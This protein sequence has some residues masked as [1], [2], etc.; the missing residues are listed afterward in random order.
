[1]TITIAPPIG[2][3][4]Q[5]R[6]TNNEDYILPPPGRANP[7]DRL[8]VVCDGVGGAQRGELASFLAAEAINRYFLQHPNQAIDAP[9][10]KAALKATEAA[11]DD[12]IAREPNE[13]LEGMSTT[14]T[15]MSLHS[16]GITIAHVGDSRVY[17]V[18]NGELLH[19][20]EDHS[21]VNELVRAGHIR[22]EEAARHPRR[23]V[24]TRAVQGSF[25]RT[26]ATIYTSPD[27]LPG[28][29]FFLCTDGV[30]E[31]FE[32]PALLTWLGQDASDEHKIAD[33]VV[34]CTETSRDNFSGY[35][36]RVTNVSEANESETN[37]FAAKPN[38]QTAEF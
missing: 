31:T 27:V 13:N 35:L 18:R 1:M 22:P 9:F 38:H 28:D 6:R 17:H 30:L 24:I 15:L 29:Y 7:N 37:L 23:N 34:R 14:L 16:R 12:A 26:N 8:F 25:N 36:V 20:T 4:E 11:F 19:Q 21:L 5:G 10:I 3:S 33:L 32:T 2:F